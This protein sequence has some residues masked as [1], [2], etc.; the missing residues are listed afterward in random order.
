MNLQ[1]IENHDLISRT[2]KLARSERKIT[3]LILLHINEIE[4]RRLYADL[5]FDGMFSF[6]TKHLAY[7]ES[8]AYRRL[9][10]ARLLKQ[11]P[12]IA[13]K[14]ETGSLNLTQLT[15][16]QKCLKLENKNLKS[17]TTP[18]TSA[19][20]TISSI[21]TTN[22]ERAKI[23]LQKIEGRNSFQTEQLLAIEFKQPAQTYEKAKPQLDESVRIEFTLN[24]EQY[25]QL[26][27]AKNLLSHIHPEGKWSD[28]ISTLATKFNQNKLGKQQQNSRS[29]SALGSFNETFSQSQNSDSGA[30]KTKLRPN[31]Q[32]SLRRQLLTSAK[33]E[34]QYTNP[35]T[36]KRCGSTFQLQL[37]HIHPLA[38]GGAHDIKN[39][40]VLCAVHNR[41]FAVKS[42]F[43]NNSHR[44]N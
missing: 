26:L 41:M 12:E 4:S 6:L 10:S 3:H 30:V 38:M 11:I 34:C 19:T 43:S 28:I 13:E 5:G 36:K 7:S 31:I 18:T 21:Q 29:A 32:K 15:Q 40:R 20:Q 22:I 25:Q 35:V 2:E 33:H 8:S 39:L 1:N 24:K 9:Q 17:T 14:L 42:G 37:D 27:Q 23:A 44:H 16:V